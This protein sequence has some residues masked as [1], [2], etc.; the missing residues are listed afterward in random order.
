MKL[1]IRLLIITFFAPFCLSANAAPDSEIPD[2]ETR[3][4]QFIKSA[5]FEPLNKALKECEEHFKRNINLPMKLP[6]IS[7][8]HQMA[9]CIRDKNGTNSMLEISHL[10]QYDGNHHYS[11]RVNPLETKFTKFPFDQ[12]VIKVYTLKDGSKA[13]YGTTRKRRNEKASFNLL[14]FEK[15]NLQYTLSIDADIEGVVTADSLVQIAESVMD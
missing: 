9:V 1:R 10:N 12:D 5:S 14:V 15:G 13:I 7:F 11:I 2:Y 6:Q 3:Y 4:D 8:T